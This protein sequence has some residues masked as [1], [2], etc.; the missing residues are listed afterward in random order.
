M[1]CVRKFDLVDLIKDHNTASESAIIIKS[2]ACRLDL[3]RQTAMT[4]MDRHD[5]VSLSAIVDLGVKR[6][7]VDSRRP[8]T[9]TDRTQ[10]VERIYDT[11][12]RIRSWSTFAVN[13]WSLDND[14]TDSGS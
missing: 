7:Y 2:G 8:S 4:K 10:H 3:P 11:A 12:I 13:T 5:R 6:D 9:L 1:K 14:S